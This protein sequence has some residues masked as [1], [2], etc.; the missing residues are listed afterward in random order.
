MSKVYLQKHFAESLLSNVFH[1]NMV[2]PS[3][4]SLWI[5]DTAQATFYPNQQH[6]TQFICTSDDPQ[7]IVR[8]MANNCVV[9][10]Y[11]PLANWAIEIGEDLSLTKKENI[12]SEE[13]KELSPTDKDM[14]ATSP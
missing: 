9:Q 13:V 6:Y 10:F 14:T 8:Q 7:E 2:H 1:M 3:E 11:E 4:L 12:E 5:G